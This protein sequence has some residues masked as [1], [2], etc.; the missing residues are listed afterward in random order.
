M[1]TIALCKRTLSPV[2]PV[3]KV[4][5]YLLLHCTGCRTRTRIYTNPNGTEANAAGRSGNARA[6]RKQNNCGVNHEGEG[7]VS[8]HLGSMKVLYFLLSRISYLRF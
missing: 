1:V 2:R 8:L 6:L 7:H 5:L 4:T 3:L